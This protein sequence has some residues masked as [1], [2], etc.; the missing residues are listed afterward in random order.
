MKQQVIGQTGSSVLSDN[1]VNRKLSRARTVRYKYQKMKCGF[2]CWVC[3][4]FHSDKYGA[5]SFGTSRIRAEAAL[6]R[7]LV[8][9][10]RYFGNLLFS[11]VDESDNV[12][13]VNPRLLDDSARNRPI[14]QNDWDIL[15]VVL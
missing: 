8:R 14:T 1:Q 9:N 4:P 11:D 12:G 7:N 3:A 15:D 10:Y 5:C 6:Q 13:N 2:L